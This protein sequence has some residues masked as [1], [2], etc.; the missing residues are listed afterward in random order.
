MPGAPRSLGR[1]ALIVGSAALLVALGVTLLLLN[2]EKLKHSAQRTT[3]ADAYLVAAIDV[4]RLVVDAETGLRGYVITT[5]SLFLAPTHEAQRRLPAAEAALRRAAL[6]DGAFTA[7]A[8]GLISAANVYLRV[9][10]PRLLVVAVRDPAGARSFANTLQGKTLV[11]DVRT[12]ASQLQSLV[13]AREQQRQQAAA[14]DA[15]QA[16]TEAIV[17][18][19]L[20]TVATL[21]LGGLLG[22]LVVARERA[23]RRSEETVQ[24]LRQ[25]LLPSSMPAIPGCELAV[26]FL[27]AQAAELVGGDFY[28]AFP[29]GDDSWALVVG[30]VCGKGAEAAAVTAMAR[31]TLRSVA[32]PDIFP[33]DALRFLN[34]TM[35][36]QE[37]G[38]RFITL[39][40]AR[41]TLG[42][43]GAHLSMACAGHPPPILVPAAGEPRT[44]SAHGPLVGVWPD[45]TFRTAECEL[46][47]GDAVVLYT[48]GV[49]DPGPGPERRPAEAL[50]ARSP[51][52]D[53]DQLAGA[54][55][56]YARM[57]G[58]PQRD[59]IAV[60]AL[61]LVDP[62]RPA[63]T[64]GSGS[65]SRRAALHAA[66]R[67]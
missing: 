15:S 44:V 55:E 65:G 12:R 53:A 26:R 20:L 1:I 25:S 23:S 40:Y 50:R 39:A 4:E 46:D 9:Y 47:P 27:P 11:D 14:S 3:R 56:E 19:V 35:L 52:A 49:S 2:T 30:D 51:D 48:D 63:G 34:S 62:R 36:D 33:Q 21:L 22:W 64:G 61:R 31:W 5:R 7:N 13:S 17:V 6:A 45:V 38:G 43:G 24:V 16:T 54:L 67:R 18:L 60:L 66:P 57:P 8:E 10:V 32:S 37:L 59:D 28:D 41:L 42:E 58:G 29:L